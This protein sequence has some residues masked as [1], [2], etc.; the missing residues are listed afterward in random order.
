MVL[1]KGSSGTVNVEIIGIDETI[2]RLNAVSQQISSRADVMMAQQA[3]FVQQEVQESI[4]GRRGLPTTVDTGLLASSINIRMEGKLNFLVYVE[5]KSYPNSSV[6]TTDT[7]TFF[8]YGTTKIDR[9]PHFDATKQRVG[10]TVIAA[11]KK[12]VQ[13]TINDF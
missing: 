9:R 3:N 5:E 13:Q 11:V 8:E 4:I 1:V 2:R 12:I 10:Q 7:A 6:T